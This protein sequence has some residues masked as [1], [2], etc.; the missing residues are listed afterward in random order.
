M[1]AEDIISAYAA[2]LAAYPHA[3]WGWS[4][5]Y[6]PE[7]ALV[8]ARVVL[9]GLNP[10][11]DDLH[12]VDPP[13]AWEHSGVNAYFDQPWGVSGIL[14]P[15]QL[16]IGLAFSALCVQPNEIFA[17]N[18][19]PFRSPSWKELPDKEGALEF[20]RKL[21][22]DLLPRTTCRLFVSIGKVAG[23]EVA[24]LLKANLLRQSEVEWPPQTIDEYTTPDGR[25][26][27]AL[28]HLSRFAVFGGGRKSAAALLADAG[29]R[30]L[31]GR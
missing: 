14:N 1:R 7:S 16:Q 26:V 30:L 2:R 21:W 25:A 17:A 15:L 22:Q 23:R 4:F 13:S 31:R 11:A 9:V 10:K 27:L 5:M 20:G 29:Q 19:V 28:P 12:G 8:R 18:F 24:T 6:T 3:R